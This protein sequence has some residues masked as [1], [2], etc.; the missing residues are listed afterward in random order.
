MNLS[1]EKDS[2]SLNEENKLLYIK[3]VELYRNTSPNKT[4]VIP[5]KIV[6]VKDNEELL[7]I[8]ELENYYNTNGS[9][10]QG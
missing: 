3:N 2:F 9:W 8:S 7:T 10:K 1:V 5:N 4:Y 6:I